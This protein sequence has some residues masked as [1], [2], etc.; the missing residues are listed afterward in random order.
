MREVLA[1]AH[2]FYAALPT[3]ATTTTAELTLFFADRLKNHLRD[4]GVGHDRIAAAF[5]GADDDLFRVEARAEALD[6]F[7][8][9]DDGRNLLVAY[10]RAANIARIEGQKD[11]TDYM[12]AKA[13]FT[14]GLDEETALNDALTRVDAATSAAGEDFAKAMGALS[15]LRAPVDAFFDK[16]T[17]N[18]PVPEE[19]LRRLGLLGRICGL[20]ND[21]ADF[22]AIEG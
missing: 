14:G 22:S 17:V 10:R 8:A 9:S 12:S 11:G 7:L 19:R 16:V 20:M 1:F 2:G 18:S 15:G 5:R 4:K 13:A 3:D 6:A 21:V